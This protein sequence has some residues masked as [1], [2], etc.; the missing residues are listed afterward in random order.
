MD[1]V[2][3]S[4]VRLA[5]EQVIKGDPGLR[6]GITLR[7]T[8]GADFRLDDDPAYHLDERYLLYLRAIGPGQYRSVSPQ[9]RVA[10]T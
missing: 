9:G 2:P 8:G 3:F 10:L 4:H 5:V 7:H 6:G 1:R